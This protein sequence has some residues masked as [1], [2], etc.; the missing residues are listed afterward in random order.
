M[1]ISN[2]WTSSCRKSVMQSPGERYGTAAI[3]GKVTGRHI[4][5][6]R[7]IMPRTGRSSCCPLLSIRQNVEFEDAGTP[8][9][10]DDV[11]AGYY[12]VRESRG[13]EQFHP[14][15]GPAPGVWDDRTEVGG[16]KIEQGEQLPAAV[17]CAPQYRKPGRAHQV[18]AKV[19]ARQIRKERMRLA[20]SDK[21]AVPIEQ[22]PVAFVAAFVP[23]QN[24]VQ[25]CRRFQGIRRFRIPI[26]GAELLLPL[27]PQFRADLLMR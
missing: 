11:F 8:G 20:Q 27:V 4:R 10:Q 24:A 23:F 17:R 12:A 26:E 7:H 3:P 5:P 22:L 14:G 13:P 1:R 16:G 9:R 19:T 6:D 2:R 18:G 25:P 21:A 15:G